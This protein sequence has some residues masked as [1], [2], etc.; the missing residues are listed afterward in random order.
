MRIAL[1]QLN[2]HIADPET[3]GRAIEAAYAEALGLGADLVVSAE[4]AVVGYLAEDRLWEGAL[5]RRVRC[6]GRG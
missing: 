5:R 1:L 4:L 2:S 6:R 3:N